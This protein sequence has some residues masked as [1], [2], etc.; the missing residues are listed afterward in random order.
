MNVHNLRKWQK[1]LILDILADLTQI[2]AQK[3]FAWILPLLVVID[4]VESYH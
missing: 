1:N 4:I 3:F 2:W